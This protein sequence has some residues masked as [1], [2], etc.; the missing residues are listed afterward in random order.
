MHTGLVYHDVRPLGKDS[1]SL[2]LRE[3]SNRSTVPRRVVLRS[4]CNRSLSKN[5]YFGPGTDT[6]ASERSSS[7]VPV[8][9]D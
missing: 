9:R 2:L 8:A 3:A 7:D 5:R 1:A 4:E 6:P